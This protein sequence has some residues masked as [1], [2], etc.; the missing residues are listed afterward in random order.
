MS[1]RSLSGTALAASM[2]EEVAEGAARLRAMGRPVRIAIVA[3]TDDAS[4]AWYMQSIAKA[5]GKVG[6]DADV[7]DLGPQASADHIASVLRD[8]SRDVG[9]AGIILQTPLPAGVDLI[10]LAENISTEKDIDGMNAH[11]IGRLVAG[12]E[13]F[14]P[15]TAEAVMALID[16]HGIVLAGR[17]A[18]VVG[19][20]MVVGKPLA[21]LLLQRD[22]TVTVAHSRT[23]DLPSVTSRADVLVA[24]VGRKHLITPAH[25]GLGATV[26]D[27]G[28]NVTDD[29]LAGDVDPE[30]AGT[31]DAL[32]PV[33]GGVGPV[34][35]AILLR[36]A[37][38]AAERNPA[39]RH[40]HSGR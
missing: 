25:V 7:R 16:H 34:T 13:A 3:A 11:S 6:I 18:V 20:S 32:S 19:R 4:S 21:H 17:E 38:Q 22:A 35:T 29:G 40:E 30:V 12:V 33:P 10:R 14:A 39:D 28:T 36:H 1:S 8:F 2:R 27:V 26:L 23:R 9:V 31:A 37:V 24:A 5:S 15:A